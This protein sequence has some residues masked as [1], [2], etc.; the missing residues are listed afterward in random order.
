M[1]LFRDFINLPAHYIYSELM[2]IIKLTKHRFKMIEFKLQ[3]GR[4]DRLTFKAKSLLAAKRI[5]TNSK[6]G[7]RQQLWLW[8]DDKVVAK[9]PAG[10]D[11]KWVTSFYYFNNN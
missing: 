4:G 9:K 3:S 5:A 10:S 7:L 1:L 8:Q 11:S 6:L 2:N